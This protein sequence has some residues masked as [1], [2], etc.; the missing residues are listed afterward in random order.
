MSTNTLRMMDK[1]Y[2]GRRGHGTDFTD[3]LTIRDTALRMKD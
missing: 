1:P 2:D 3:V